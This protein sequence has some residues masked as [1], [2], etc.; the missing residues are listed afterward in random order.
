MLRLDPL[1][2]AKAF[3]V[4]FFGSEEYQKHKEIVERYLKQEGFET[5]EHGKEIVLQISDRWWS[6]RKVS[7]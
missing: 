3:D 4:E 2:D 7:I 5:L 1:T 6:I